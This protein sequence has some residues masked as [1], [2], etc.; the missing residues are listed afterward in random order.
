MLISPLTKK[1]PNIHDASSDSDSLPRVPTDKMI[2]TGAVAANTNPMKPLAAYVGPKSTSSCL[3]P[4]GEWP[5]LSR[6]ENIGAR[7]DGA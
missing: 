4:G 7:V 6:W 1:T 3:Q 2:A 5:G